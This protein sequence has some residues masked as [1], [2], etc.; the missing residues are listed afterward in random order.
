M[1]NTSPSKWPNLFHGHRSLGVQDYEGQRV[2]QV[3]INLP[4]IN[5]V[6]GYPALQIHAKI[7]LSPKF[8]KLVV[9]A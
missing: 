6:Y 8:T 7:N 5:L 2:L 1:T 4:L 9:E 3:K